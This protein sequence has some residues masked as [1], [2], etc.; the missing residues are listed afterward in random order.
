MERFP[1]W[2]LADVAKIAII[3]FVAIIFSIVLVIMIATGLPWFRGMPMTDV[4]TDARLAT[5]SQLLA[6]LITLW[7]VYR[8][9]VRHYGIPFA[10]GIRWR[11]PRISWPVY[12]SGG[13]LLCVAIQALGHMLPQPKHVPLEDLFRTPLAAWLL[14]IFGTFIGPPAEELFFRGLLFPALDRTMNLFWSVFL[15]ALPF[16]LLHGGQLAFSWSP[17]LGIFIVGVVLTLVRARAESL[18]ASVLVHM[19]YNA[20][21]FGMVIYATHGFQHL[22]K[23]TS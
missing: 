12:I 11:W 5:V 7:F 13:I 23:L 6:Y 15:T 18:A 9:I 20:T 8:L 3:A 4:V 1:V 19:A 21:T 16:A 17:L 14:T 22:Q 2:T 10:E